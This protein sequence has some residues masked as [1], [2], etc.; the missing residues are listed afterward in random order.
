MTTAIPA[1][2]NAAR[3]LIGAMR[4]GDAIAI[5]SFSESPDEP[6]KF[7][8]DRASARRA[9]ARL[10]AAGR[11]AL[12]DA[13]GQLAP[14]PRKQAGKESNRDLNG[15]QRQCERVELGIGRDEGKNGGRADFL[16]CGGPRSP[17]KRAVEASE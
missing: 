15:R 3:E 13:I 17:G 7:T 5:Y 14:Q 1:L 10:R 12:F 8:T 2:K 11:T 6:Q 16:H 9:L 4:P